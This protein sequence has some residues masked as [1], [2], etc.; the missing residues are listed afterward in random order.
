MDK[1]LFAVLC[2]SLFTW[3]AVGNAAL[4]TTTRS[5]VQ[6]QLWRTNRETGR[7]A[8]LDD[9]D[10]GWVDDAVRG[11]V[12]EFGGNTAGFLVAEA[13]ELPPES[14]TIMLWAYRDPDLAGGAGGA[15][16]GLF[17]L[18]LGDGD[19]EDLLVPGTGGTSKVV[20]GWVQ[21]DNLNTEDVD[22][23]RLVW[24]R[25]I[26]DSG[27]AN[28]LDKI[29]EMEDE[30]WTHF[31]YRGNGEDFELV[32]NGDSGEGISTFMTSRSSTTIRSTLADKARKPG[33]DAS[34]IFGSTATTS[35]MMKLRRSWRVM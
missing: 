14:F 23:G 4:E 22:E 18:T 35:V 5:T 16:D 19:P 10:V 6:R 28:N 24:G 29:F 13:P 27:T 7:N 1:R 30:M 15:N 9:L 3:G 2:A 20:G 32:I 25:V 33:A 21:K 11:G 8:F 34:M 31:A 26:D 12:M 17:Q